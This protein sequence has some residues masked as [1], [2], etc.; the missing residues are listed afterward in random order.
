MACLG[1]SARG[2]EA[3]A[4]KQYG[5][6]VPYAEIRKRAD[7]LELETVRQYGVPIL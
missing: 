1:L 5:Q 7:E 6:E 4:P 2:A 3:L